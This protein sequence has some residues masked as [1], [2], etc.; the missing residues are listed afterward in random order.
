MKKTFFLTCMML[1]AIVAF[2]QQTKKVAILEVVDR[3]DK[4]DYTDKLMLRSNLA[5]A[6]TNIDGYEAYNRT[7]LDA[8]MKEHDF[9]HSGLVSDDD[10]KKIGE[11]T[12]AAFI[13]VAEGSLARGNK[14][15]ITAQ[16]INVET[17]L[18]DVTDNKLVDMSSDKMLQ[19][20]RALATKMFGVLAGVSTSTNKFMNMFKGKPKSAA[21]QTADSIA[22][23][24]KA[25]QEAA[26]AAAK[27]QQR[28]EEQRIRQERAEAEAKVRKEREDAEAAVREQ[29]RLEKERKKAEEEERAKY[30]IT[31]LNG[32]EYLYLGNTM[33]KKE[34]E[35]FLKN[36][37]PEAFSQYR[38]GKNLIV[39]GWTLFGIGIA[40]T[41]G[42]IAYGFLSG[43]QTT[44][45]SSQSTTTSYDGSSYTTTTSQSSFTF[46]VVGGILAATG[47][48]L[49]I[50]SIPTMGVGYSKRNKALK[51]YNNKCA[52][53][54]ILPLA[55]NLTAGQNGLGLALQF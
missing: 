40:S 53:S 49:V 23:V 15:Y 45:S 42:G 2:A 38:S 25:E 51:T 17:T 4:L 16:I 19:G 35:N 55:L 43:N 47:G 31:K 48:G 11:M 1:C 44:I 27:E 52:S 10:I 36:N 8:V 18:V 41:A 3:E 14:I 26:V 39:T 30:Y 12:G 37:C 24:R 29:K 28:I 20:C 22:A 5:R 50:A 21:Q 54:D 34:Y 7:D 46:N 32:N 13:L 9:Q 33:T 6:V